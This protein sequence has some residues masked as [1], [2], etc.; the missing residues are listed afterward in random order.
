MAHRVQLHNKVII[1]LL[2]AIICGFLFSCT[3]APALPV[4][5]NNPLLQ[6]QGGIL[7]YEGK[8]FTGTAYRLYPDGSIARKTQ[9][10]D[11]RE[12]GIMQGWYPGKVLQENRLFADGKKV[13]IHKGWWPNGK[14][15]FEYMFTND[16][17]NGTAKEWFSDGKLFRV[18]HYNM[19][20]EDGLQQMWW[21][22]G[23][24]RANYV[25]KDGQQYGLIGRKL[26]INTVK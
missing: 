21:P 22:D 20:H 17:H 6:L 10:A 26:C 5:S 13:G 1:L 25:V 11:G 2:P 3:S 15:K 16:E 9:Y 24:I 4:N 14:A 12:D 18:F 8:P 23:T 7:C 19:G